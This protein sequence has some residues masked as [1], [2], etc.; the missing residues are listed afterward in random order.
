MRQSVGFLRRFHSITS[1][2]LAHDDLCVSGVA[3]DQNSVVLGI[4][5]ALY[6]IEEHDLRLAPI[7]VHAQLSRD[8]HLVTSPEQCVKNAHRVLV[9]HCTG[10]VSMDQDSAVHRVVAEQCRNRLFLLVRCS[11]KHLRVVVLPQR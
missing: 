1:L 8:L 5:I 2:Q 11:V 4:S 6:S 9:T 3:Q 7:V 10:A